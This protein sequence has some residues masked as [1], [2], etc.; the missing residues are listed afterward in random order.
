MIRQIDVSSRRD[1]TS[2]IQYIDRSSRRSSIQTLDVAEEMKINSKALTPH[3]KEAFCFDFFDPSPAVSAA[4]KGY[5]VEL[6]KGVVLVMVMIFCLFSIFWGTLWKLPVANVEGFLV[7][8]HG[9]HLSV[10]QPLTESTGRI[11]M[12]ALLARSSHNGF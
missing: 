7:V 4:R 3:Q 8:W 12:E 2:P 6:T 9:H 1:R 11:S 10:L 5:L